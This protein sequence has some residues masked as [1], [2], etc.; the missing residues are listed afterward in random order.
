MTRAH[1]T[2]ICLGIILTIL[3]ILTV[4][5]CAVNYISFD[6]SSDNLSDNNYIYYNGK[7]YIR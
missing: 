2:I 6:N 5:Y 7:Y 1:I 3:I 4:V